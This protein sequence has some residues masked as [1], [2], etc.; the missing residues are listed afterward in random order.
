MDYQELAKALL[1][2]F[3]AMATPQ[4]TTAS[5]G[6]G[7]VDPPE[8]PETQWVFAHRTEG[9]KFWH[10]LNGG[11]PGEKAEAIEVPMSLKGTVTGVTLHVAH[12]E[13]Y[14]DS[15]KIRI[16]LEYSGGKFCIQAG[17]KS[18]ES[19]TVTGRNFICGLHDALKKGMLGQPITITPDPS[20][21]DEKVL[22][23]SM[24]DNF[25]NPLQTSYMKGSEP[26]YFKQLFMEVDA[27]LRANHGAPPDPKVKDQPPTTPP[28]TPEEQNDAIPF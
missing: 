14:G 22:F 8:K 11:K 15:T 18:K 17:V 4:T 2:E 10:I 26:E 28:S 16:W 23:I 9:H 24:V 20:D 6:D 5:G 19:D 3:A 1:K 21:K 25:G 12:H 13:K 7:W 27:H